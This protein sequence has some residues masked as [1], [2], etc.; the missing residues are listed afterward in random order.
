M[1]VAACVLAISDRTEPGGGRE[2][3]DREALEEAGI[4]LGTAALR[5]LAA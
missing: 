2:R 5:A 3:L 4:R 1:S